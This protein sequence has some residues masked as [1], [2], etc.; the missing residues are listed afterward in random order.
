MHYWVEGGS[1]YIVNKC[2][3]YA[4]Q[5]S[6]K[7]KELNL[8]QTFLLSKWCPTTEN[9][10]LDVSTEANR[11]FLVQTVLSIG[12][13]NRS[14]LNLRGTR[15]F[16]RNGTVVKC[17]AIHNNWYSN[18]HPAFTMNSFTLTAIN[19]SDYSILESRLL[20]NEALVMISY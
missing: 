17:F 6:I 1:Y 9:G 8:N 16:R 20:H 5:L 13:S 15:S 3:N 7:V 4:I 10:W 11:I 2:R 14:N 19:C 18:L 12:F